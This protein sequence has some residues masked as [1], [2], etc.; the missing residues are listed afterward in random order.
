MTSQMGAIAEFLT[1]KRKLI[2]NKILKGFSLMQQIKVFH[3]RNFK[4]VSSLGRK[5]RREK[6]V[7]LRYI[8]RLKMI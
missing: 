1:K 7:E 8:F 4:K 5:K 3:Y 2:F 6:F